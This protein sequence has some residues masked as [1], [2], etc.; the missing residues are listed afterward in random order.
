MSS[1][2]QVVIPQDMRKGFSVGD[3]FV[4]IKNNH[5]FVLKPV[6]ELGRNFAEDMDFA[7]KTM[8]ALERYEKGKFREMSGKK[9]LKE[10][11]KW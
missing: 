4:I 5:Q 11:E 7:K 8:D 1:K 3:R 6:S 9:F 10:L 2:G